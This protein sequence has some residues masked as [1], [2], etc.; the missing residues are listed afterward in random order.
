MNWQEIQRI[1][2]AN[3]IVVLTETL[4]NVF[5]AEELTEHETFSGTDKSALKSSRDLAFLI[6]QSLKYHFTESI[7]GFWLNTKIN[8]LDF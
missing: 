5:D 4:A 7:L 2:S 6:H 8:C 3:D 1:V